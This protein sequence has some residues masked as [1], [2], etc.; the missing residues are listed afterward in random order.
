MCPATGR[1]VNLW[2]IANCVIRR[3][4][5]YEEWV[6][7]NLCS[8]LAQLGVDI[9]TAART[10]GNELNAA[11]TADRHTTE[12]HRI[13]D[14]QHPEPWPP[15][16]HSNGSD[17]DGFVR[18]LFHDVHNRHDLSAI[19]RTYATAVRWHGACDRHGHGPA[20]VKGGRPAPC[21]RPSSTSA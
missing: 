5:I 13:N 9:P 4:E 12:A 18:G 10:Y 3:N 20:D 21:C 11:G 7:Y 6:L 17:V 1:Q 8:K 14:G 2:G 15:L 19:D 16:D